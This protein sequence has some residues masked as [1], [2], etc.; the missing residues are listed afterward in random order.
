LFEISSAIALKSSTG[1][2]LFIIPFL[3]NIPASLL[4]TPILKLPIA[5]SLPIFIII[6]AL[7]WY[8]FGTIAYLIYI[9]MRKQRR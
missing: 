5:I 3:I 7:Q 1:G 6:G 2:W 4:M 9:R 8:L